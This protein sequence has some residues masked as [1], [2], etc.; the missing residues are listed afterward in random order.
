V[1]E[2]YDDRF[3]HKDGSAVSVQIGST[4]IFNGSGEFGGA[5]VMISD[6]SERKRAEQVLREREKELL[7]AQ[8]VAHVGSWVWDP[9]TDNISW[10]QES[11]RIAGLDPSLPPVS[12]R[13]QRQFCTPETSERLQRAVEEA[14]RSGTPYE[15]DL[16]LVPSDSTKKWLRTRGEAE[17]DAT[18]RI[19]LL[20]G[21][22][23]D[24]TERK[25]AEEALRESESRF[26][27][28]FQDAGVG[29]IIA[30][31][32]GRFLAVNPTFCEYLGYSEEELLRMSVEEVT[33][34]EDWPSFWAKLQEAVATGASFRRFEK[35]CRHK[36]GCTVYTESSAFLIQS[37]SGKPQYFV[38]ET[39]NVTERKM[40]EQSLAQA[41]L[42][43]ID[44]QEEERARIARDLHDDI[45]QR[46]ALLAIGLDHLRHGSPQPPAD[47]GE[48]LG[49]L[50]RQTNEISA[51]IQSISHQLHPSKLEYLGIVGAMKS[52][53]RETGEKQRVDVHFSNE[54]IPA[55]VPREASICLFRVL[56]E[57]LRNAMK[58][59][60]VRRFE[61]YLRGVSGGIDLRVSDSGIG[62]DIE[63]E[64]SPRGL[65][66][67]SMRERVR[68]A[69]GTLS[70]GTTRGR[71]TTIEAFV[72]IT[73]ANASSTPLPTNVPYHALTAASPT[74]DR[75]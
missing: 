27:N 34:P 58:H 54:N 72:P 47:L 62:F 73:A 13:E 10:S 67:I 50:L 23:Q 19:V 59:S 52:F 42:R 17:R 71:G 4:P 12:F 55:G 18:G 68:L 57:A 28:V 15:L 14:L 21:T 2:R 11:Y 63:S 29:M 61:V 26:R 5:L 74:K 45:N 44:A 40:A 49:E 32:D 38:G 25:N 3:R 69:H 75:I 65:G 70:I 48:Q 37:P 24:I 56:Q 1:R 16:E 51:D 41:N 9:E 31:L 30:S 8:R 66:L 39:V 35:R 6:I 36:S 53:C 46:L 60:G 33:Q 22:V 20:R 43:L 7:E 64:N